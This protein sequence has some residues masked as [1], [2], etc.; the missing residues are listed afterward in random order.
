MG[1]GL[2]INKINI[3]DQY[4]NISAAGNLVVS[5]RKEGVN[6]RGWGSLEIF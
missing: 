6:G 3:M 4:E 2:Y 1:L 5:K